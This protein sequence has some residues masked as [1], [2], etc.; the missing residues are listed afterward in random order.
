MKIFSLYKDFF[1]FLDKTS[2]RSKKWKIYTTYYY[3]PHREFLQNYFSHFPFINFSSLR[4]RVETIKISDYSQLKNLIEVCSPEEIIQ[5]AYQR[6]MKILSPRENPKVYLL[7][8]FFSPDGFILNFKGKPVICFGLERFK[9]FRLLRILFAHEYAH[10]LLNL[11]KGEVPERKKLDWLLI[12]EG[13]ATY[14]SYSAFPNLKLSDH[15]L[16][17]RDRLNWCQENERYL[18]EIY[19]SETFSK[20]ELMDFYHKGNAELSIPPRAGKY[21]GFQAVKKYLA[22]RRKKNISPLFSDKK[23]TLSLEL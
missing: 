22:Q 13:I 4:Q 19:C 20:R 11:S 2:P 16:F 8:G 17:S 12:S 14:L 21:L 23:L 1:K 10:F 5:E 6:C 18:R 7:I 9:D 3:E 15:F